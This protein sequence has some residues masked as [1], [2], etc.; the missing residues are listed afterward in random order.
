MPRNDREVIVIIRDRDDLDIIHFPAAHI[1]GEDPNRLRDEPDPVLTI[2]GTSPQRPA[3]RYAVH[4]YDQTDSFRR[5]FS[6]LRSFVR[7]E[8]RERV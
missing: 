6:R 2:R 1:T 8:T 5:F 4:G 7:D 3:K